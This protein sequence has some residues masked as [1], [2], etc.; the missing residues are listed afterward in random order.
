M[1][2][3]ETDPIETEMTLVAHAYNCRLFLQRITRG[4]LTLSGS[5][6]SVVVVL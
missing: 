3:L 6:Q 4:E 2:I 5:A 1:L